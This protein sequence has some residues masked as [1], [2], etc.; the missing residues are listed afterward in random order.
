MKHISLSLPCGLRLSCRHWPAAQPGPAHL[1]LHGF[2]NDAAVWGQ[3]PAQ[4]AARGAVYALDFR[5]HGD[6]D[7]DPRARYDHHTLVADLQH[8]ATQLALDAPHVIGHSLG[9]RVALLWQARYRAALSSLTVVDTGPEVNQQA[10]NKVRADAEAMPAVFPDMARW[11]AHLRGIYVLADE[12]A[13]ADWG[14]QSVAPLADG[15][16]ALKTDPAFTRALWHPQHHQGLRAPLADQLWEAWRGL[17][18]PILLLRGQAS[19]ILT[20][21]S[22]QAMLACQPRARLVTIPRAGHAV[23]LD[24]P[25]A[26]CAEVLA[27]L[28]ALQGAGRLISDV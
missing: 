19:A 11:L 10:A 13:L 28:E 9:A 2:S 6:A 16:V 3:L 5:G 15:R 17:S 24:N 1:L 7:R 23:M 4:L 12:Q 26:F 22:A 27:F 14:R 21:R 20:R 8:V 25:A 18:C